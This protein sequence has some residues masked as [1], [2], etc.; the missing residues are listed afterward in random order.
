[1]LIPYQLDLTMPGTNP[2][3]DKSR[4]AMRDILSLR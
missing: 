1:M 2:F 4:S 3:E